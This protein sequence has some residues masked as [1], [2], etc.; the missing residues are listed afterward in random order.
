MS[1]E[2]LKPI[3][4]KQSEIKKCT[5]CK[6]GV[7]HNGD[8]NFW[9]LTLDQ[10]FVNFGAVQRQHGLEQMLGG[11]AAIASVMGLNENIAEYFPMVKKVWVCM[12]CMFEK[13][14]NVLS[15]VEEDEE[16]G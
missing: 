3:G 14:P 4:I 12:P 11:N 15:L 7:G 8:V 6:K 9:L 1:E 2:T 10:A 5:S 13:F 16:V